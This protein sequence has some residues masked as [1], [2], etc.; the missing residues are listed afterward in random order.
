MAISSSM[1]YIMITI[2]MSNA[3]VFNNPGL[4]VWDLEVLILNLK[5][6]KVVLTQIGHS[7]CSWASASSQGR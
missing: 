1:D 4:I 2:Y 5:L 6:S 7:Y 3:N